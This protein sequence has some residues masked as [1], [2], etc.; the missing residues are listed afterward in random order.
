MIAL[1][2]QPKWWPL[3]AA[4]GILPVVLNNWLIGQ[5]VTRAHLEGEKYSSTDHIQNTDRF[6][7]DFDLW[8]S[9]MLIYA[10]AVVGFGAFLIAGYLHDELA[11]A[12]IVL[13]FNYVQVFSYIIN[14]LGYEVRGGL[15]RLIFMDQRLQLIEH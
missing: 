11:Y 5:V 13:M 10:L 8:W 15:K 6:L 7:S 1:V 2:V 3:C 4:I 9:M 14:Q 12:L